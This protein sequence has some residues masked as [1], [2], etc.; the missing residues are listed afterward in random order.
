MGLRREIGRKET[1][2]GIAPPLSADAVN[3]HIRPLSHVSRLAGRANM[4][5]VPVPVLAV[6]IFCI[7]HALSLP[8]AKLFILTE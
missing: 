2:R 5:P 6:Y 3:M 1:Y 4:H 8:P 7:S